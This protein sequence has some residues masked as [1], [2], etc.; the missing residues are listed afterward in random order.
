M[1]S[2]IMATIL[3]ICNNGYSQY[4]YQDSKHSLNNSYIYYNLASKTCPKNKKYQTILHNV[5]NKTTGTLL[6]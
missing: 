2:I 5:L 3:N 1:D 6:I 4:S